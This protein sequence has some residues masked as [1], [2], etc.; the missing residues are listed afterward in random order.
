MLKVKTQVN[1]EDSSLY[2]N[3]KD[4]RSL[5]LELILIMAGKYKKISLKVGLAVTVFIL[6]SLAKTAEEEELEEINV[7]RT[8]VKKYVNKAIRKNKRKVDKKLEL[9]LDQ[10]LE[11]ITTHELAVVSEGVNNSSI[12]LDLFNVVNEC[13]STSQSLFETVQALMTKLEAISKNGP[14]EESEEPVDTDTEDVEVVYVDADG[15][16]IDGPNEEQ[17]SADEEPSQAEKPKKRGRPPKNQ[18]A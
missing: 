10:E 3:Y 18:V 6:D 12:I 8:M 7:S 17:E 5:F 1:E 14:E 13:K 15:N 9:I 2:Y 11:E 16:P 4:L